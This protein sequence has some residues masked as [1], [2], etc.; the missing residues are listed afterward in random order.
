MS[1][2][3][4][5]DFP[6][7]A[8][9][10][11]VEQDQPRERV[12]RLGDVRYLELPDNGWQLL[13][14]WLAGPRH[15]CR[16]L[17]TVQHLATVIERGRRGTPPRTRSEPHTEAD[18]T[19]IDQMVNSYLH[20]AGVPPRPSRFVWYLELPPERTPREIWNAV[21]LTAQH[22]DPI[23]PSQVKTAMADAAAA[24]YPEP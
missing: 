1:D 23:H 19:T 12:V 18:R 14:A 10:P 5:D 2:Y 20:E 9:T 17:D 21:K 8:E 3:T 16:R 11:L 15:V 4:W 22:R 6:V 24:L 7:R 13:F